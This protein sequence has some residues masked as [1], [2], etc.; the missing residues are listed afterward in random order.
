M[1]SAIHAATL[2]QAGV[3][4]GSQDLRRWAFSGRPRYDAG[5]RVRQT[6]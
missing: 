1:T 3:A 5:L 4:T 6:M 2:V